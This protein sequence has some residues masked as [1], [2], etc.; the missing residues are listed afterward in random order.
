MRRAAGM[1]TLDPWYAHM[2]VMKVRQRLDWIW[3]RI[4]VKQE[5]LG[6][7][8]G[9]QVAP[10]VAKVRTRDSIQAF[11]Q[12]TATIKDEP[13]IVGDPPLMAPTA[14]HM[15]WFSSTVE[16]CDNLD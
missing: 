7:K 9:K 5:H 2:K 10:D 4:E 11:S 12:L 6:K 14:Q 1:Y 3:I 15:N 13:R 16:L 8:V